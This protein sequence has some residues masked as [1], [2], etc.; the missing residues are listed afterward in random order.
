MNHEIKNK[1]EKYKRLQIELSSAD[2]IICNGSNMGEWTAVSNAGTAPVANE[3]GF[4]L[5]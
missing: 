2:D 1:N 3:G 4:E 5:E